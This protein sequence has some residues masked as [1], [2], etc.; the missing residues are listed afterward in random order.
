MV[1]NIALALCAV[2]LVGGCG[3][4]R[5]SGTATSSSSTSTATSSPSATTAV[6]I[7]ITGTAA[8]IIDPANPST[9]MVAILPQDTTAMSEGPHVAYVAWHQENEDGAPNG[10]VQQ[11]HDPIGNSNWQVHSLAH[12]E[13]LIANDLSGNPMIAAPTA[14]ACNPGGG[15]VA[16]FGCVPVASDFLAS[17]LPYDST[18]ISKVTS[19]LKVAGRLALSNGTLTPYVTD[20]CQWDILKVNALQAKRQHL[21]G[22]I[23]YRFTITGSNLILK[24]RNLSNPDQPN[25]ATALV[26]LKPSADGTIEMSFG[27]SIDIFPDKHPVNVGFKDQHFATYYD[28]LYGADATARPVPVRTW[29]CDKV[30]PFDPTVYCGPGLVIGV[31]SPKP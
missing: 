28:V 14:S 22:H 4:E 26:S 21:A 25:Q 20:K 10:P 5:T 13:L 17:A 8:L 30:Q 11:K 12:E 6:T 27:N 2:I 19:N 24:L 1:R 31:G 3:N 18:Y 9:P 16:D 7:H 15:G 29:V 23:D